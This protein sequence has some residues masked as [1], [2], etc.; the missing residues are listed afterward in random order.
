MAKT[1]EAI[2]RS[3]L[4]ETVDILEQ[5]HSLP[6][7]HESGISCIRAHLYCRE[8]CIVRLYDSWGNFCRTL[9]I[10]SA[11]GRPTRRSGARVPC[12]PNISKMSEVIPRLLSTFRSRTREPYWPSPHESV[13]AA[14]RLAIANQVDVTSGIGLTPS[15][16]GEI[17]KIR[18]FIA[19][20]NPGT[21]QEFLD[22]KTTLAE[23]SVAS[24]DEIASRL[25]TPGISRFEQWINELRLQA[26][27]SCG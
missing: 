17:R 23:H 25:V 15:P 9:I 21:V 26:L 10:T 24:P 8:H 27:I 22:A 6:H 5:F 20:R 18:N 13:D 4:V 16:L 11:G 2:Y 1:L 14:V 12:A 7:M 19:H 3:F